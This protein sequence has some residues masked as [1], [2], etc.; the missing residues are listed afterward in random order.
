MKEIEWEVIYPNRDRSMGNMVGNPGPGAMHGIVGQVTPPLVWAVLP[1]PQP[2]LPGAWLLPMRQG[3]AQQSAW[4]GPAGLE[5]WRGGKQWLLPADPP[6]TI[7]KYEK[8]LGCLKTASDVGNE[9][10]LPDQ[11]FFFFT[12][13]HSLPFGGGSKRKPLPTTSHLLWFARLRVSLKIKILD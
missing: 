2:S 10:I 11:R 1:P 12:S 6:Q 4:W 7:G 3:Q 9:D 5:E 8:M 13:F